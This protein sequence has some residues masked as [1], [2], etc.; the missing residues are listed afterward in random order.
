MKKTLVVTLALV[1]VLGL[2]GTAFAN[3][4]SDVP[5]GHWAYKAVND[6]SKAGVVEGYQGKYR[7]NDN[8]T[9]Y[10]MAAITARA[11][12]KADK[13]DAA[14][15]ATIDK[16]AVEFSKE[17]N[18]LGVRVAKLEKNQANMIWKGDYRLRWVD[19][20]K[21]SGDTNTQHRLRLTAT[22]KVNDDVT[23]NLRVM[24][25]NHKDLGAWQDKTGEDMDLVD[26]NVVWKGLLGSDSMTFGRF[27][28]FMGQMGYYLDSTGKVDGAKGTW[29]VGDKMKVS[30]G[31]ADFG[32]VNNYGTAAASPLGSIGTGTEMGW[33]E[34][35]YKFSPKLKASATY[36]QAASTDY[37][38]L[39][40]GATYAFDKNW[41]LAGDYTKIT[42]VADK[43]TDNYHVRLAYK[44][45]KAAEVGSWGALVEYVSFEGSP[46]EAG[47]I[48]VMGADREFWSL[49]YGTALAKN[50]VLNAVYAFDIK[51]A[52]DGK[53]YNSATQGDTFTRLEVNFL[54]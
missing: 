52:S 42:D 12:A 4:Y 37:K 54:F 21:T 45:A 8:M 46:L 32:I 14:A 38:I 39:G 28:Q 6:L 25:F 36:G 48:T 19:N 13:A 20:D 49:Q 5:A 1:F 23:A 50:V 35:Q 9:R 15:K 2:A 11:M 33:A 17:L 47:G 53:K 30:A 43:D 16:L 34:L 7:G 27:S 40:G 41:V 26:A 10:E 44:G 29:S 18:D 22:A 24:A 3:P 31:F 51:K